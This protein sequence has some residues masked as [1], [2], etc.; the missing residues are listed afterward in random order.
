[1]A[2]QLLADGVP[3]DGVGI[4]GH[5]GTQFGFFDVNNMTRNLKRFTDLGLQVAFTEADVRMVLPVDN[6]KVQSQ[7]QGYSGMMQACLYNPGCVSF[8]VWG[9]T[10][11]FQWVPGFFTG[12]GSA[13]LFDENYAP[14]PAYQTLRMDLAVATGPHHRG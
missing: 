8:T 11:K 6:L 7:S 5:L 4:Q 10:D 13:A 12:Q 3:I 9:F 14:K 1:M 2:Q